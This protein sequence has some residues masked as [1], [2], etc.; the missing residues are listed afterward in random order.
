MVIPDALAD[1]IKNHHNPENTIHDPEL[2]HIVYLA[3]LLM[4][5]FHAGLE[6]ERIDTAALALRLETIGLSISRLPEIVDLI[7]VQV[8]G[9]L[10][11]LAL[12]Y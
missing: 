2:T 5:R 9:G 3:D 8:F 4:A 12:K 11:E 10:P 1:A 7:P 6:L